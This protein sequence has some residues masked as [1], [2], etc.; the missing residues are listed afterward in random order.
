MYFFPPCGEFSLKRGVRGWVGERE[1]VGV[2][3]SPSYKKKKKKDRHC[4]VSTVA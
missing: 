3:E 4:F 2:R 1:W